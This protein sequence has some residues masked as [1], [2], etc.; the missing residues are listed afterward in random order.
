M[1][2]VFLPTTSAWFTY[3]LDSIQHR[4]KPGLDN[5][6]SF[7]LYYMTCAKLF[8]TVT[9]LCV[10]KYFL[11]SVRNLP[12]ANFLLCPLIILTELNLKNLL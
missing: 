8:Y 2:T 4:I 6:Q 9:T 12:F 7:C 1:L 11:T 10:K 5:P 3:K